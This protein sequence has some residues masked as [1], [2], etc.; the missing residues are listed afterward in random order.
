MLL[1]KI[2]EIGEVRVLK[3]ID[4]TKQRNSTDI[5]K[6]SNLTFAT[7]SRTIKSLM[8]EKI[9]FKKRIKKKKVV[10]LTNKGKK[11]QLKLFE[12]SELLK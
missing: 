6:H 3:S 2:I 7:V 12:L 5:A 9:V 10:L 1:K 4:D 11:I 8:N